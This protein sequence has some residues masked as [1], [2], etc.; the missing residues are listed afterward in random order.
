MIPS[1][2][3]SVYHMSFLL[4]LKHIR[5]ITYI[6]T[7]SFSFYLLKVR[8]F[9]YITHSPMIKFREFN[10]VTILLSYN[11]VHIKNPS[12]I[13]LMLKYRSRSVTT[14]YM[15]SSCFFSFLNLELFLSFALY[16]M[17]SIFLRSVGQLFC[18]MSLNL[19]LL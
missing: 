14:H 10:I 5:V 2:S 6:L 9:S 16:F 17:T 13:P 15:Q 18:N 19:G 3:L 12:L 7:L 8:T 1:F 11:I 4:L